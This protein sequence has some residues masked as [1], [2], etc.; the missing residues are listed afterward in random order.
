MKVML[1]Y[2]MMPLLAMLS[3][4]SKDSGNGGS[5]NTAPPTNLTLSAVVSTDN[6]GNV[7]FTAA[8]TNATTYEFDFG[9]GIFQN[10]PNG[11]VSYRYPTSGNYTVKVTAKNGAGGSINKTTNITVT[12]AQ[13]LV[14][15]DEFNTDGAPDPAKWNYDVGVGD[16]GW[17]NQELQNY[18]TRP[19]NAIVQGGVLKIKAIRENY[20]GST[21]TSARLKSQGK[22]EF[23]YGKVEARAKVPGGVGTWAAIWA[24]GSDI[25]TVGWP[26]CGEIDIMEHLGR[27]L[28]LIY[29]TLHYPGRSGGN[30]DGST[31]MITGADTEFHI[32]S[33]EWTATEIKIKVDGNLIHSVQT[34]NKPFNHNFFLIMNLAMGGNFGGAVDPSVNGGTMEVDYIRVY[35]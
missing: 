28:N 26:A 24:L 10:V 29:G 7:A 13:S 31:R 14:W 15:S 19:E 2:I 6:S 5:G 16:G 23:K 11:I 32:Y 21:F 27:Q 9:N 34:A 8:A 18:T 20:N 17:G 1:T 30:A 35:Q 33:T 3:A 22:Y 12:V 25:T 4:C